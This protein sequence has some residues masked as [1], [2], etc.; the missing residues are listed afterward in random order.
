[1]QQ[2]NRFADAVPNLAEDIDRLGLAFTCAGRVARVQ[3]HER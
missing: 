3:A 2:S 1:M